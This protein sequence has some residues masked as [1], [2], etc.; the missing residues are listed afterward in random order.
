LPGFDSEW[1]GFRWDAAHHSFPSGHS[2]DIVT[3]A[4]F[5]ALLFRNPVAAAACIAWAVAVGMSR[6]AVAKHYPSD[7]LAGAVIAVVAS[8]LVFR[9]WLLPR[10]PRGAVEQAEGT[11][12]FQS[13]GRFHSQ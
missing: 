6:L 8:L 1:A 7:A 3:G 5:A 9:F 2:A 4:L 11:D 10:L 13:G 12:L